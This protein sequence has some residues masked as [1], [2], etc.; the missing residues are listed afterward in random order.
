MDKKLRDPYI[1]ENKNVDL[2]L[3]YAAAGENP[4]EWLN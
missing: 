4:L 1:Y 2:Y 3:F